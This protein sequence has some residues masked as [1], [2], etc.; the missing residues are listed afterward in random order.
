[1]VIRSPGGLPEPVTL[2]NMREQNAARNVDVI[3][4]L[5]RF[6]LAED[7]GMGIDVMEDEME[8]ALLER[9]EFDADSSYVE[10]ALRIGSTVTPQERA[11]ISEIERRGDIRSTDRVLLVHAA[12][13]ELLTNGSV[14]DLLGIDSVHAR[15]SL[16]RLRDLGYL[17]QR[18]QRAGAVYSIARGLG[19]PA[20]LELDDSALRLVILDIAAGGH[21]TNEAVRVRTGLDRVHVLSLLNSMVESGELLRY[22]SRRGTYYEAGAPAPSS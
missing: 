3:R 4:T 19:P 1:V 10:V 18:G 20:G 9:P 12:R 16:H 7:A 5:R 15:A 17:L 6:R 11:W 14:R 8:A 22:G 13:G 21:V 2:N